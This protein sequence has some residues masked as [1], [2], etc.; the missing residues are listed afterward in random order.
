MTSN[1]TLSKIDNIH[2]L[3]I[4]PLVLLVGTHAERL[5]K[6]FKEDE[7]DPFRRAQRLAIYLILRP[8]LTLEPAASDEPWLLPSSLGRGIC[9]VCG[10]RCQPHP[11]LSLP[12]SR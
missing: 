10:M 5:I 6:V 1:K 11:L 9:S 4:V 12:I 7:D 2:D 3:N 8:A